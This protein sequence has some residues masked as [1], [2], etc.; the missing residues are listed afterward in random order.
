M[1][2]KSNIIFKCEADFGRFAG[3]GHLKRCLKLLKIIKKKFRLKYNYIFVLK[4]LNNT[5]SIIKKN[6]NGKYIIYTNNLEKKLKFL[7]QDDIVINDT[8]KGL[9]DDFSILLQEKKIKKILILDDIKKYKQHKYITYINSISYFKKK[10][11]GHNVFQGEKYFF[12]NRCENKNKKKVD[13]KKNKL[14]IL[15]C[16]G[17]TDYKNILYKITSLLLNINN[18]KLTVVIGSGVKKNNPIFSLK[19]NIK[20]LINVK[21]IEQQLYNND[22]S[23]VTGGLTMFESLALKKITYVYQSYFH[24]SYA[25]KKLEKKKIISRIGVNNNIFKNKLLSMINKNINDKKNRK[26]LVN[27]KSTID[28][29]GYSRVKKII[30][31]FLNNATN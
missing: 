6:Y 7:Q 28:M 1:K 21:N 27:K 23:I 16:S 5:E 3:T 24:Q 9:D 13:N 19:G 29:M 20:K 4:K 26:I 18:I 11:N 14:K 17:G 25:I 10:I 15:I 31:N 2:I 12:L 22:I 8:P 30:Y